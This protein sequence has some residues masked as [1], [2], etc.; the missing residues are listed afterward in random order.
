M[1]E[2][3]LVWDD[4][5]K[6]SKNKVSGSGGVIAVLGF[7]VGVLFYVA[8]RI[9]YLKAYNS[10]LVEIFALLGSVLLLGWIGFIDDL[11]GW[12]KGGL[13]KRSRIILVLIASI[14]LMA[15]NA[16]KSDVLIPFIGNYELGLIYP[17]ILVPLGIIGATTTFNFLAG[18][19]GL[20]AGQGILM[21]SA[22]GFVA[23]FTGSAWLGI[24]ALCMIAALIGFL[25]FNFY[26]AKVFPGDTITY[27][28][29]GLIAIM[30]ILGNFEKIALFFFIPYMIETAL[31]VRGRLIKYSFGEPHENGNLS[32]RY[33]KIYSLNHLAILLMTKAR[34]KPT[35]K[36]V[37]VC[38]WVFQIFVIIL[39]IL[40]F[41]G[42]IFS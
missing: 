20:E 28:L 7:V 42:G 16:G 37:V 29:G 8:Y 11:M 10:F 1:K 39:G 13:S 41:S 38:V 32:L 27:P 23:F 4:M 3:G 19:N 18:F 35:E 12:R 15:I 9:F 26:P 36:K 21:L 14:P 33:N 34:I 17:L 40:I 5:N 25:V 24:I 22:L 6:I 2:I 30:A 31:K